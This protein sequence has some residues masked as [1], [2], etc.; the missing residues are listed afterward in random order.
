MVYYISTVN[1]KKL[2]IFVSSYNANRIMSSCSLTV[3]SVAKL[4]KT[5]GNVDHVAQG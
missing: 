2:N 1:K 3:F 5:D 4:L